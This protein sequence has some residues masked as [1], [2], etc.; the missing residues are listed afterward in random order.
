MEW[1]MEM[2]INFE[3]RND[4]V[5]NGVSVY[6][7]DVYVGELLHITQDNLMNWCCIQGKSDFNFVFRNESTFEC[8]LDEIKRYIKDNQYGGLVISNYAGGKVP[9]LNRNFGIDM[10]FGKKKK[11]QIAYIFSMRKYNCLL[12]K[13]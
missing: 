1:R 10:D 12:K 5:E 2:N 7:N 11:H 13:K 8:I 9:F 6:A 4:E 3:Y